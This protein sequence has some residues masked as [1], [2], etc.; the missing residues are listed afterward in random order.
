MEEEYY[1]DER[2]DNFGLKGKYVPVSA[3]LHKRGEIGFVENS[4]PWQR[5][6]VDRVVRKGTPVLVVSYIKHY[7]KDEAAR[8]FLKESDAQVYYRFR[9]S[10]CPK[11][12]RARSERSLRARFF[13]DPQSITRHASQHLYQFSHST[14]RVFRHFH[15]NNL[16]ILRCILYKNTFLL[17]QRTSVS[18]V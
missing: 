3:K 1:L 11:V 15:Q 10:H 14:G 6:F 5:V 16:L 18:I 17:R 13:Q 9:Q 12:C 8:A 2:I 7:S 4:F